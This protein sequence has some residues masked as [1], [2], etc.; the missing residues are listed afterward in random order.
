MFNSR[1]CFDHRDPAAVRVPLT[2]FLPWKDVAGKV[3]A[4]VKGHRSRPREVTGSALVTTMAEWQDRFRMKNN[5]VVR[6]S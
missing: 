1:E 3:A 2:P 6:K 5:V 4:R